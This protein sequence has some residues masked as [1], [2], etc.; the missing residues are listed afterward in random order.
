MLDFV[1]LKGGKKKMIKGVDVD[2]FDDLFVC[3]DGGWEVGLLNIYEEKFVVNLKKK[4]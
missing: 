1:F 3:K 2:Y 4:L